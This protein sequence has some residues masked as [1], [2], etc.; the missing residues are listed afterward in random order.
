M[1]TFFYNIGY[2]MKEAWRTI[3][4]NFLSNFFSIIGTGLIL[5]L[6][7]L[8]T[9]GTIIGNQ[10]ITKLSQE[11][12]I[13][14]YFVEDMGVD[15]A[16]E[17]V[18]EIQNIQGVWNAKLIDEM[19]ACAMMEDM[20][21]EEAK[22]L[23]LFED[24]PFKAFIEIRIDLDA[25]ETVLSQ[26]ASLEGIDYV[27]D[28]RAVLKQLQS[29]I[30]GVEVVG[31]LITLAVGITTL[32]LLSHMI[33]QGIYNNREQINTL[34]LL[35]APGSF[36]GF[37]YVLVGVLLTLLGGGLAIALLILLIDGGYPKI[38]GTIPFLPLPSQ[39]LLIQQ[40]ATLIVTVSVILGV[41]GSLFGLS[42]I[43]KDNR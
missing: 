22:I 33:R 18:S 7:G 21:G 36:I 14:A 6:L 41:L 23:E 12:E 19:Q 10:F 8:V 27:R 11:A 13:S 31:Y 24:N 30:R 34:R 20:L 40:S 37:P 32:I 39:T 43:G 15:A 2:F 38:S 35:G 26:V 28:N 9:V 3:R 42:S 25:M 4:M 16:K 17:L 5:F 1:K 29:I